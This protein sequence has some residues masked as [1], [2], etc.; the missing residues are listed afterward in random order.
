MRV[1]RRTSAQKAADNALAEAIDST[2]NT[3]EYARPGSIN[4]DYIV[5]VNQREF[6]EPDLNDEE[7]NGDRSGIVLLYKDGSMP[8]IN[9]MGLLE[10]ARLRARQDM[11]AGET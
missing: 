1:A 8:W 11:F 5:I 4:V 10:M 3:Y 2:V 7:D 6:A 9:I